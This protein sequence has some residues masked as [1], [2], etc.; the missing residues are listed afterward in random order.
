MS[1]N[2]EIDTSKNRRYLTNCLA[3]TILATKRY[4][5]TSAV[6]VIVTVGL[7]TVSVQ[8][9]A[10]ASGRDLAPTAYLVKQ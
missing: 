2:L 6:T 10:L 3:G 1:N 8:K 9:S 7:V 4:Q 5:S